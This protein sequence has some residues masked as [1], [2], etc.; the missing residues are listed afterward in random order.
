[1]V[2]KV[3]ARAVK[4]IKE[5]S[6][7]LRQEVRKRTTVYIAA[8]LGL[9]VGLAWNEAIKAVIEYLFPLGQN[10]MTAKLVYAAVL[11]IVL[12]I[13]TTYLIKEESKE[14]KK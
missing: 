7:E 2:R 13:V 10:T 3:P 11:T 5:E 6:K 9:V 12:V 8:A 4:K 1:M 14:E